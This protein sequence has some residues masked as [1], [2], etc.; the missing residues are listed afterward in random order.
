MQKKHLSGDLAIWFFIYAELV[1][2]GIFFLSYAISRRFNLDLFTSSQA[3]LDPSFGAFNTVLLITGS[4]FVVQAVQ[5]IAKNQRQKTSFF[6]LA[7]LAMGMGFVVVKSI[8]FWGKYHEGFRLSS[9]TFFMFYWSMTFFHYMHVLLGMVI[10]VAIW[11]KNRRGGYSADNYTGIET[12]AAYWH[13]VDLVWVIL[14]P[15]LY[16]L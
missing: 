12:G 4:Y 3:A 11:L 10:I 5:S 1:V 14:F 8:E 9:N 16:V 13:M 15:L 6:L 7:T 2:F